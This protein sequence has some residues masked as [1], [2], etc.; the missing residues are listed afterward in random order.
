MKAVFVFLAVL[1]FVLWGCDITSLKT[2][3][4]N[5][6]PSSQ[7]A[8]VQCEDLRGS[9]GLLPSSRESTESLVLYSGGCA[10]IDFLESAEKTSSTQKPSCRIIIPCNGREVIMLASVLRAMD[11]SKSR[12]AVADDEGVYVR[13]RLGPS[14]GQVQIRVG[15]V[16]DI[17]PLEE[18]LY[19]HMMRLANYNLAASIAKIQHAEHLAIVSEK[20]T[21]AHALSAYME[22]FQHLADWLDLRLA[23]QAGLDY[24]AHD[25]VGVVL[26]NHMSGNSLT[27]DSYRQAWLEIKRG[28][29]RIDW[30]DN[31]AVINFASDVA[32]HADL[33]QG[34]DEGVIKAISREQHF[35]EHNAQ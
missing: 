1:S 20:S 28:L 9:S 17:A 5:N 3:G 23:K 21:K 34:V 24:F 13:Y 35:R 11:W 22:G 32:S 4:K 18:G 12:Q 2:C 16:R 26:A 29:F 19:R 14:L 33:P 30:D 7:E 25:E 31:V 8:W 15:I 10:R 27:V 6:P